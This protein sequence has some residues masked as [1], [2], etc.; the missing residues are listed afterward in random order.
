[1]ARTRNDLAYFV[2]RELVQS[3]LLNTLDTVIVEPDGVG[4]IDV[5]ILNRESFASLSS[6]PFKLLSDFRVDFRELCILDVPGIVCEV[7]SIGND[8]DNTRLDAAE[9]P[10]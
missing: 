8:I 4:G 10:A 3:R 6:N 5:I 1:M 2:S 9:N 7:N